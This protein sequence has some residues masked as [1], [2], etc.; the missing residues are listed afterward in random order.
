M[1]K[2]KSWGKIRTVFKGPFSLA[3]VSGCLVLVAFYVPYMWWL[4]FIAL[5]PL[6]EGIVRAKSKWYVFFVGCTAGST[7]IGGTSLWLLDALPGLPAGGIANA[8]GIY[9]S[10]LALIL[11][12]APV[13]GLFAVFIRSLPETSS[14]LP[15]VIPVAWVASE[16][17]RMFVY[18]VLTFA[19][20]VANPA[21]YSVGFIGY[22]L[23]DSLAWLQLASVG[24]VYALGGIVVLVNVLA[25]QSIRSLRH[26][27]ALALGVIIISFLPIADIRESIIPRGETVPVR[28]GLMSVY[29]PES[30]RYS[31]FKHDEPYASVVKKSVTALSN[32]KPDVILLPEGGSFLDKTRSASNLTSPV[33][34]DLATVATGY[35]SRENIGF[36]GTLGGETVVPIRAK[37]I[38]TPQGEYVAG[39]ARVT[40]GLLGMTGAIDTY[41][42]RIN[43]STGLWGGPLLIPQKDL[44]LS[45]M[46]CI[47]ALAPGFGA[48][49]VRD[50]NSSLLL[51][52]N[53]HSRFKDSTFLEIDT[54]RFLKVRGVEAG[55]PLMA[56]ADQS[57]AYALDAYGRVLHKFG[58]KGFSEEGVVEIS[59]GRK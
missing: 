31:G 13:V 28:V 59:V 11:C 57:P 47:E 23:A 43:I 55:V 34:I 36:A 22:P 50:D 30:E 42:R 24:G 45:L 49:L 12:I 40:G 4:V 27:G 39:I 33:V 35:V 41:A 26:I 5:V 51:V 14:W 17:V 3:L 19:P 8:F 2:K 15:L 52:M 38:L 53:S 32:E 20:N 1:R 25:W 58:G 48:S 10:W 29:T 7:I 16:Y 46:F 18:A 54:L 21:F 6:F 37:R 44:R 56:S 9:G